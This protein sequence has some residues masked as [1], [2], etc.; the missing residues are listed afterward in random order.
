VLEAL[1]SR[2]KVVV[3]DIPAYNPW[4]VDG[5]NC[6]KGNTIDEFNKNIINIIEETH[7]GMSYK[8]YETARERSLPKISKEL[9]QAYLSLV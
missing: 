9:K 2:Q 3:R 1:A 7:E 6:L 8:A 5:Q 4:L